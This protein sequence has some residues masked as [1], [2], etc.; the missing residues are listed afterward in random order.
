MMDIYE[1]NIEIR[2]DVALENKL[3]EIISKL[4]EPKNVLDI[5]LQMMHSTKYE[6]IY[7]K[8]FRCRVLGCLEPKYKNKQFCKGHIPLIVCAGCS[9]NNEYELM[10]CNHRRDKLFDEKIH[11][12][13]CEKH[14]CLYETQVRNNI[15]RCRGKK[16]DMGL[17]KF[18]LFNALGINIMQ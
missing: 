14:R 9:I 11:H 10:E 6:I 8:E 5:I 2:R 18:H 7:E 17:C 3:K 16:Y 15:I 1:W 4:N 12:F 13:I